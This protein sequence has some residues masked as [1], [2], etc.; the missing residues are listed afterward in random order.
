M[1]EAENHVNIGEVRRSGYDNRIDEWKKQQHIPIRS[2]ESD[3]RYLRFFARQGEDD[4]IEVLLTCD[5][6][7]ERSCQI[8]S[9]DH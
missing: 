8:T 9:H 3:A 5:G 1:K 2:S 7:D 4:R 6:L